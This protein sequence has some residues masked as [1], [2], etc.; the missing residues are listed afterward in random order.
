M[1]FNLLVCLIIELPLI[2]YRGI[3]KAL[4]V[5]YWLEAMTLDPRDTLKPAWPLKWKLVF[6]YFLSNFMQL[7]LCES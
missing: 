6:V 1:E 2:E 7:Q 5:I 3:W 4:A